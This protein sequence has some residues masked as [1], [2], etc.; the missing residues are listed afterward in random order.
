MREKS[1]K[2]TSSIGI[3]ACLLLSAG[4]CV[5]KMANQPRYKPLGEGDFWENGAA[6]RPLIPG[7]VARG[8]L[9]A[10]RA[11][12]TGKTDGEYVNTFPFPI[13][14]ELI[15]RGRARFEI[16]CAPCHGRLGNGDGMVVER[17]FRGVPSYHEDRFLR[18]PLGQFFD[19]ITNGYGA[20]ASYAARVPVADRWAIIAYIRALQYSQHAQ[21]SDLTPQEQQKL[22]E[23]GR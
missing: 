7:T 13:T 18:A 6:A 23:I 21:L 14:H 5:Q 4:G 12:Y 10:D 20:M 2:S 8:R 15:E 9:D 22:Q 1:V 19:V 16:Y 3:L 17:G 11:Y